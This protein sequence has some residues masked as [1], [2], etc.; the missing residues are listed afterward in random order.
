MQQEAVEV[1]KF[2]L[3]LLGST[4]VVAWS[5]HAHVTDPASSRSWADMLTFET[6]QDAMEKFNI[7]KVCHLQIWIATGD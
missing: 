7:E 1:G 4:F 5:H 2:V 6:A 3:E